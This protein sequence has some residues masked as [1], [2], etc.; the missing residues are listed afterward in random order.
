MM[1]ADVYARI[2]RLLPPLPGWCTPEKG[3][4]MA[5]L[6]IEAAPELTRPVLCVELGVFGGR[7]MIAMAVACQCLQSG[8]IDGIDPYTA[9]ASL[10]GHNDRANDEWWAKVD[11]AAIFRQ[12]SNAI[13]ANGLTPYAQ[14]IRVKSEDAAAGYASGSVDVLHQDSNHSLKISTSEVLGWLPKLRM[15]GFWIQDDTDWPS[16]ARAQ[17]MLVEYGCALI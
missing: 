12:A 13:K 8:R 2:D 10:E 11:Y 15:G 14:I 16:T 1:L 17:G 6:V 9:A 4:R 3:R 7:S 5:K